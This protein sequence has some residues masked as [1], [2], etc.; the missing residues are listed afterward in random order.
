MAWIKTVKFAEASA[1][2][3]AALEKQRDVSG[4]IRDA[5][6]GRESDGGI[7]YRIAHID[8]RRALPRFFDVRRFAFAGFAA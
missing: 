8:S 3:L 1:E 6:A 2:L 4:G 7:D 5:R